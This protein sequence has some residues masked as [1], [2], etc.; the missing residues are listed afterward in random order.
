M[1]GWLILWIIVAAAAAFIASAKNR[2]AVGWGILGF[3][4]GPLALVIILVLPEST[5]FR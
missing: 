4:F 2:S 5:R 3:L 1:W